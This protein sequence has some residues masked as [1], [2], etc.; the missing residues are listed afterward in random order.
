MSKQ[1]LA[2]IIFVVCFIFLPSKVFAEDLTINITDGNCSLEPQSKALFNELSLQPLNSLTRSL[3]VNNNSAEAVSLTIA[4]TNFNE[5]GLIYK[6]SKVLDLQVREE[7]SGTVITTGIQ[8]ISDWEN[9]SLQLPEVLAGESKTYLFDISMGDV[10]NHYQDKTLSF[11]LNFQCDGL[12]Q[13][14]GEVSGVDDQKDSPIET[15][16]DKTGD[17]LG[18][19]TN[20]LPETGQTLLLL[21]PILPTIGLGFYLRRKSSK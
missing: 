1:K 5:S 21:L 10:G 17:V 18:V 20:R 7:F 3:V 11:D 2:V 9:I 15:F 16:V 12:T 8:T 19:V 14:D 13:D 4:T 6:L